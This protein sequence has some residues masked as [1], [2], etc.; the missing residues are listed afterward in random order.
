[1]LLLT[2]GM[3]CAQQPP[4]STE[5]SSQPHLGFHH[6][7]HGSPGKWWDN[8]N[9]AQQLNLTSDQQKKMDEV[10]EQNRAALAQLH[11]ALHQQ[12]QVMEPLMQAEHPD[13]AQIDAQIDRLA[14]ARAELEKAH[15]RML[16][17]IRALLTQDQW[18]KLRALQ[19]PSGEMHMHHRGSDG[20]ANNAPPPAD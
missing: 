7:M 6:G 4:A 9:I 15:S 19:P 2:A 20:D 12:E 14:Q 11:S 10:F 5:G 8:P 1:M 16:L 13:E 3:I 18:E 17:S